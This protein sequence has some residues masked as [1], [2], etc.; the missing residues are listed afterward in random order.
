MKKLFLVSFMSISFKIF[1]PDPCISELLKMDGLIKDIEKEASTKT[2]LL[3]TKYQLKNK[4][5][6]EKRQALRDD[7][8]F[9]YGNYTTR[10]IETSYLKRVRPTK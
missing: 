7:K 10:A 8:E 6:C 1:S 3:K 5:L 4:S 2:A 9:R